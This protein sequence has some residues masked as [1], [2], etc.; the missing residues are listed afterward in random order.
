MKRRNSTALASVAILLFLLLFPAGIH[1]AEASGEEDAFNTGN[2]AVATSNDQKKIVSIV[3][4]DS[5]SM[6]D[7]GSV[8]WAYANYAMQSF[9]ALLGSQD[10][11]YLTTTAAPSNFRE[12]TSKSRQQSINTIYSYYNA[13]STFVESIDT[14][15]G[16]L[17]KNT[18]DGVYDYW[19]VV[20]S[21][22]QFYDKNYRRLNDL[23]FG[24]LMAEQK[25]Q[26][27]PNGTSPKLVYSPSG[28]NPV[29]LNGGSGGDT[30][31]YRP[32]IRTASSPPSSNRPGSCRPVPRLKRLLL[33]RWKS[34]MTGP[35]RSRASCR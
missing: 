22:G 30:Y 27:M 29:K 4:D 21:D 28:T 11:L 14:A 2:A 23:E 6:S 5:S 26:V 15:M 7:G 17:K 12:I 33:P 1:A 10:K 8:N 20:I 25:A 18:D 19:L 24:E 3:Y 9:V 16:A 13:G 32:V 35:S 34:R 31:V